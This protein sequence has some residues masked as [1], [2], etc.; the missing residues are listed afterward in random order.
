[1]DNR[2][3]FEARLMALISYAVRQGILSDRDR[4]YALNRLLALFGQSTFTRWAEF[5]RRTTVS[6]DSDGLAILEKTNA[7]LPAAEVDAT[8]A[9]T[10]LPTILSGLLSDAASLG[11]VDVDSIT[12][13]DLFDTAIM[14]CVT[15]PPS[16]VQAQFYD[17]W[18]ADPVDATNW[19]YAFAQR[20]FFFF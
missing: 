12:S 17:L 7:L 3:A 20:T 13:C 8:E 19:A 15:A 4:V 10:C 11:L 18:Q 16:Q 14:D 5:E 2:E 1:M 6:V 9:L